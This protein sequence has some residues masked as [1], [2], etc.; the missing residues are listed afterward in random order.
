MAQSDMNIANQGFPAFRSDLNSALA[1]LVSNSSGATA[2]TATFAHQ[3]WVD[4]SANPSVLKVRNADNDAWV[5]VGSIN[6]TTDAF[7]LAIAQG[8]TGAATAAAAKLALEVISAST[9]S[10]LIPFGTEAQRDGSPAAGYLRFNTDNDKFEGYDGT[11]W[12][13]VGANAISDI[14]GLQTALDDV[15]AVRQSGSAKTGSYTLEATD[16]GK[17]IE[18]GSGGSVTIPDAVFADGDVVTL[19]NNTTG[20]ITVTCSITTAYISGVDSDKASVSL[21]TRGL[22][23]VFFASGTVCVISGSVT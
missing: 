14:S 17:H 6:Q 10:A 13:A 12:G 3:F 7:N 8:G 16:T 2:P 19:F 18:I 21:L 5:T 22:C 9:G 1:A 15:A 20:S 11:Q 23:T 4:T